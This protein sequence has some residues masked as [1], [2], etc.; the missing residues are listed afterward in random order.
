MALVKAEV[1]LAFELLQKH[2]R[3]HLPPMSMWPV[4]EEREAFDDKKHFC[5]LRKGTL[6]FS[7]L[8][9]R[10]LVQE[11]NTGAKVLSE[12][13]PEV[14]VQVKK[15]MAAAAD[16]KSKVEKYYKFNFVYQDVIEGGDKK[17]KD[18]ILKKWNTDALGRTGNT[19]YEFFQ[20]KMSTSSCQTR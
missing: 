8:G 12:A 6:H 2:E 4:D 17:S 19:S 14:E 9:L 18:D 13:R 15:F 20:S 11:G 5:K 7:L 3:I 10:D 1:L 16:P